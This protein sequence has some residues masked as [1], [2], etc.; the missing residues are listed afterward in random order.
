[1]EVQPFFRGLQPGGRERALMLSARDRSFDQ[2]SFLENLHVLANGWLA[3]VKRGGKFANCRAALRQSRQYAAAGA[4]G[5]REKYPV[6]LCVCLL[7]QD[8]C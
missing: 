3:D 7:H 8:Y 4:I 2:P 1:M 6:Q 5:K